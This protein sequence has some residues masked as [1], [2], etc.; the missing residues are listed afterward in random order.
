[1]RFFTKEIK[2]GITTILALAIIYMGFIFLKGINLFSNTDIYYVKLNNVSGLAPQSEVMV[3]G[4]KIGS[5]R[6]IEYNPT[7]RS[8]IVSVEINK[9]FAILEGSTASLSKEM[10]GSTKLDINMPK[11]INKYMQIGDTIMGKEVVDIM[12][13]A[14][15]MLPQMQALIPKLDS[16]LN[17]IN[18][19]LA[20]PSLRNSI[21]NI[22][23]ITCEFKSTTRTLN[24][25]LDSDIPILL[26]KATSICHNVEGLTN[27]LNSVDF[28]IL[29]G[30]INRT[31]MD[32]QL[33][34][35]K[36]NNENSSLGLLLNDNSIYQNL[37]S[38]L[39]N[40]SSLLKDLRLHPKRYVHF[41][42]FG[43][44]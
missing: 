21:H 33:F 36:L 16:T 18:A 42:L 28:K 7:D 40:A 34:T 23:S 17:S 15:D 2:I 31:M 37:D 14:A 11:G 13:S 44:K 5:V 24:T 30:N 6:N 3:S 4:M 32:L 20:D 35:N 22:E 25:L 10:L 27:N 39:Y 12:T 41:S 43:R 29:E 26:N 1:M 38:T 9:S 8:I 19:I